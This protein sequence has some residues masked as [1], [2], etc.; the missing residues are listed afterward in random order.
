DRLN[1]VKIG[2]IPN[3]MRGECANNVAAATRFEGAGLLSHYFERG[4]NA[5][6]GQVVRNPQGCVIGGRL[7]VVFGVEPQ[8]YVDRTLRAE[9]NRQEVEKRGY[10]D[11]AHC[12][13]LATSTAKT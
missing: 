11:S 10:A 4:A 2:V 6:A 7:D 5:H 13:A 12:R 9:T 3:V 1:A 8:D